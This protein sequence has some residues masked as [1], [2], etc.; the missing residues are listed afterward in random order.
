MADN[1]NR[2]GISGL[3]KSRMEHA[4]NEEILIDKLTGEFL[5]K[6]SNGDVVS[7][8]HKT[9]IDN[10]IDSIKKIA[11]DKLVYGD[12]YQLQNDDII[13]PLIPI[14]GANILS[15]TENIPNTYSKILF[16]IDLSCL[17]VN[18][19]GISNSD[20]DCEVTIKFNVGYSDATTSTD[21]TITDLISN[22]NSTVYNIFDTN[23]FTGI[24]SSKTVKFLN[25]VSIIVS[26]NVYDYI[27]SKTVSVNADDIRH[28]IHSIHVLLS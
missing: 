24:N 8:S 23:M 22:I 10:A 25:L 6:S 3:S 27:T 15:G 7:Y 9:R 17:T 11:N 2:V 16:H 1:T 26:N 13:F 18:P 21:I 4:Y 28:I 5:V 14:P 19:D 20:N 12:I